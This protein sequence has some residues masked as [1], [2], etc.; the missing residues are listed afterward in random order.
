M[1]PQLFGEIDFAEYQG[2]YT[3]MHGNNDFINIRSSI[4]PT[5]TIGL[6]VQNKQLDIRV[7]TMY[8][9]KKGSNAAAVNTEKQPLPITPKT[10][11]GNAS[12]NITLSQTDTDV[13]NN[14]MQDKPK[15]SLKDSDG[16]EL[17]K[18]QQEYFKDSKVR[19]ENGNLLVMYHGTPNNFTVFK[20]NKDIRI[21]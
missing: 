2:K 8:A 12:S 14:S 19:D 9:T 3:K 1:L 4:E 10:D 16:N 11:N 7:Q 5:I 17:S 15:Y 20:N 6:V 18:Q 21:L 13:N